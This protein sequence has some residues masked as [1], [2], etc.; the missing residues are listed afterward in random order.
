MQI[1]I[2]NMFLGKKLKRPKEKQKVWK[3]DKKA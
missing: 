3:N 2:I 1:E